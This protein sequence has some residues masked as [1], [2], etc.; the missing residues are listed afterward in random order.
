M[1]DKTKKHDEIREQLK[2][3]FPLHP[4][5]EYETTVNQG[6]YPIGVNQ[7]YPAE[8][9][10]R[11]S[12]AAI[13]YVAGN[14]SV[15]YVRKKY[16]NTFIYEEDFGGT[17]RKDRII[18]AT[19]LTKTK[20]LIDGIVAHRSQNSEEGTIGEFLSDATI[21]RLHYSLQR[22]FAEADK[23]ALFDAED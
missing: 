15:D 8:L 10:S 17:D 4:A 3:Y 5:H 20:I 14:K 12:A 9:R 2:K 16:S 1:S 18:R 6:H 13:S 23:G 7:N 11:L 22:A 19:C 21:V